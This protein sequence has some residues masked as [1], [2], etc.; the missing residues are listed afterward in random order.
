MQCRRMVIFLNT[1]IYK[2]RGTNLVTLCIQ[3]CVV[4]VFGGLIGVVVDVLVVKAGHD[5]LHQQQRQKQ[6]R[7]SN[8]IM[9]CAPFRVLHLILV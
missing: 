3:N 7:S 5:V 9:S 1:S 2:K 4:K 6:E 8:I